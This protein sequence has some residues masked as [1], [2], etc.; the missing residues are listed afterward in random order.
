MSLPFALS[1]DKYVN[2][3]GTDVGFGCLLAV[4]LLALLYFAGARE[5][6]SLRDQ[7]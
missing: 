7:N 3:A 5:T 2:S 1:L 6:R 4:A